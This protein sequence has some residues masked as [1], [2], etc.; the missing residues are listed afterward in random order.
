M[1]HGLQE[2]ENG[3]TDLC[4]SFSPAVFCIQTLVRSILKRVLIAI[5]LT[6][7]WAYC[8]RCSRIIS[9]VPSFSCR[10]DF[11]ASRSSQVCIGPVLFRNLYV[12]TGWELS[13][14]PKF[15]GIFFFFSHFFSLH[16][17]FFQR[18]LSSSHKTKK[19]VKV[20]SKGENP[21]PFLAKNGIRD[22]SAGLFAALFSLQIFSS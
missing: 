22:S 16:A 6:C 21:V 15:K 17:H 12:G 10:L 20:R 7:V 18:G 5:P 13:L 11:G 8:P 2:F 19:Y 14:K 3:I 1:F 4:L 9:C